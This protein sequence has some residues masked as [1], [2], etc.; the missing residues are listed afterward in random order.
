MKAIGEDELRIG[1]QALSWLHRN[2]LTSHF[3]SSSGSGGTIHAGSGAC[4][5][6]R[7]WAGGGG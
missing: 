3:A 7:A 2:Q 1:C 6:G 5:G 4:G